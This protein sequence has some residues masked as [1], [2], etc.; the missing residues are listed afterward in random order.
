[1]Q[2]CQPMQ[3]NH[4]ISSMEDKDLQILMMLSLCHHPLTRHQ[5]IAIDS[6]AYLV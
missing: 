5:V 4:K 3:C 1:M 6:K 2:W